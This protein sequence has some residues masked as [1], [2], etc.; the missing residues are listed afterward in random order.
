MIQAMYDSKN[1]QARAIKSVADLKELLKSDEGVIWVHLQQCEQE[2]YDV[3]LKE[4]FDF[5]PLAI[6]DTLSKGYQPPKVDDFGHYLFVVVHA[7]TSNDTLSELTTEELNCFLGRN[8][9]VTAC[10]G[11]TIQPVEVVWERVKRDE[12]IFEKGADFLLHTVL[13]A[14]VDEFLPFL[15]RIDEEV[16]R[17]EDQII[18]NPQPAAMRRVLELKHSILSLRRVTS[19]Q[20]EVM[21][22][23]SRGEFGL[24]S[25]Q[26]AIY[27]RDIYDH[28][29]R[30]ND[31]SEGVRDVVSGTLDTYLSV[32]SNKLNEVMKT[33]TIMSTI[34]L[35][36][37]LVT[38]LYGMN[39]DFMPELHW[40]YGYLMV[41]VL[42][43]AIFAGMLW[44]FRRKRWL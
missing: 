18:L 41:W 24:L 40:H 9:L 33:L 3:V 11:A 15:D 27:F 36:L 22:R 42:M 25:E 39:F 44:F 30:I 21:Q 38:S 34:F 17:L 23:L 20:R 10:H 2:E 13:D 43:G 26:S 4:V 6:E 1:G 16:D 14:V 12:R 35:P 29:V 5:H 8:Y 7:I 32:S 28:L 37:T 19:P 31:L